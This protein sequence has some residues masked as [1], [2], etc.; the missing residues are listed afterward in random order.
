M[1]ASTIA[2]YWSPALIPKLRFDFDF[3]RLYTVYSMFQEV[4]LLK[5]ENIKTPKP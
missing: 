4:W 5:N 2:S 1:S 3:G